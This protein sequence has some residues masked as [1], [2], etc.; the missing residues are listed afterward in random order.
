L[1][2][3]SISSRL[4]NL[5]SLNGQV[6]RREYLRV[7]IV[8]MVLKYAV[9]A[10]TILAATG[11]IYTPLDFLSPLLSTRIYFAEAG[12]EWL[13]VAWLAWT[14]PFVWIAVAMTLR[15]AI[16]AGITPWV[17][18]LIL[19]PLVNFLVMLGM[20]L[21]LSRQHR[22]V[23]AEID[24]ET[25]LATDEAQIRGVWASPE[26][27]SPPQA[28]GVMSSETSAVTAALGGLLV[29]MAY[30]L[31]ITV[32]SV[33]GFA[34]YGAVLFFGTP[35]VAGAASAFF[36]N[37]PTHR[38][39]GATTYLAFL[40]ILCSCAALLLFGLEGAVCIVMALP[41]LG[42][43]AIFG[44]LIGRGIAVRQKPD[45]ERDDR[46]MLG[47]LLIL[48]VLAGVEPMLFEPA[49]LSVT[50][51]VEIDASPAEV[52]DT[53]VA[54]P[55][56]TSEPAW[57]F[58]WG[59][60][61]P[62][63]ARIE[64]EGVGAVRHCEFTTGAFVEPITVWDEPRH[65]AFDVTEQ[66]EPMFELTPYRHIHPPHL[67]GS[68]RSTRG[69]FVLEPLAEGGTRLVGTTWYRLDIAPH[70]YWH[71]WTDAIVHRIHLRVLEHIKQVAETA[72]PKG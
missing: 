51:S 14:A 15:R 36:F 57:Y 28:P 39:I 40:L 10:A 31:I 24:E 23:L 35:V 48:P 68:F 52:W 66:P 65:L 44:A 72:E 29:G 34:S 8:L 17:A 54:F 60:A 4:R 38:S 25:K 61:S 27:D 9:E 53:V 70:A 45:P 18:L 5:F 64:G 13:S 12:G 42:P 19:V 3:V 7:G 49:A 32:V 55:E 71:H 56:I 22:D 46:G 59:I 1:G 63:R 43:L 67:K 20:A 50:T 2:K 21:V 37:R 47:C 16:D 30:T 26:L 62:L 6:S 58:R 69:E 11:L 33:Y 41:I